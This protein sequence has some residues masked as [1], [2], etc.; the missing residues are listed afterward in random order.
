MRLLWGHRQ[1]LIS[2]YLKIF[3]TLIV[4]LKELFP[5]LINQKLV[6]KMLKNVLMHSVEK[7]CFIK[8]TYSILNAI[9]VTLR[10]N[11]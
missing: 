9:K 4:H 2:S 1:K 7:L 6:L 3:A 11:V 10:P 8:L 5:E